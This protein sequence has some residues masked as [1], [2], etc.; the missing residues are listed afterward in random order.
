MPQAIHIGT[1]ECWQSITQS[2]VFQ[3]AKTVSHLQT[4]ECNVPTHIIIFFFWYWVGYQLGLACGDFCPYSLRCWLGMLLVPL[5]ICTGTKLFYTDMDF[6]PLNFRKIKIYY[7]F[8]IKLPII[9][10]CTYDLKWRKK[11]LIIQNYKILSN[12]FNTRSLS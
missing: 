7:I 9:L 2:I 1:P 10:T 5:I 4:V 11:W 6:F 8:G 3:T 12:F